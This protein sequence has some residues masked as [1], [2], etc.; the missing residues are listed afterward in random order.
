MN[1]VPDKVRKKKSVIIYEVTGK[2][3]N[4]A[5]NCVI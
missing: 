3:M 1:S 5:T 2:S 4:H